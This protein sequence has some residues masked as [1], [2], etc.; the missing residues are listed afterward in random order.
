VPMYCL[1]CVR[2][3]GLAWCRIDSARKRAARWR[4][5]GSALRDLLGTASA[6][7][8]AVQYVEAAVEK[9]PYQ[10]FV[11][12]TGAPNWLRLLVGHIRQ[13]P[14]EIMPPDEVHESE[15]RTNVR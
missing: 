1:F 2:V 12:Q 3:S 10:Y 6:K 15:S 5:I 9:E 13:C 14:I 8:H 11:G 7:G 4:H